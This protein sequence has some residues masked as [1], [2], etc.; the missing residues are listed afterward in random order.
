MFKP[1][2]SAAIIFV[3]LH[4]RYDSGPLGAIVDNGKWKFATRRA[5]R[6]TPVC[7]RLPLSDIHEPGQE[8]GTSAEYYVSSA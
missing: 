5:A 2:P 1:D 7:L 6:L 4:K 3:A 8:T